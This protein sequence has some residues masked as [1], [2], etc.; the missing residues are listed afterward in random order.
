M[1][2][3]PNVAPVQATIMDRWAAVELSAYSTSKVVAVYSLALDPLYHRHVAPEKDGGLVTR[4]AQTPR[5]ADTCLR[6]ATLLGACAGGRFAPA[7][8]C[9]WGAAAAAGDRRIPSMVDKNL[10]P[11]ISSNLSQ[12]NSMFG[13]HVFTL[14]SHFISGFGI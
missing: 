2:R 4:A 1:E 10:R 9:A 13:R 5:R 3:N 12:Q 8:S 6:G 14:G 7:R 11:E